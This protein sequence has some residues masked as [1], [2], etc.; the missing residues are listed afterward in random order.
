[1]STYW[2]WIGI[3]MTLMPEE[4]KNTTSVRELKGIYT[5]RPIAVLGAGPNLP[6]DLEKIPK[7]SILI[8]VNHHAEFGGL[9]RLDYMCF[10]DSPKHRPEA[11]AFTNDFIGRRLT[12]IK[13][14]SDWLVDVPYMYFGLTF[15]FAVWAAFWMGGNPIILCGFDC[16]TTG[17]HFHDGNRGLN[18]EEYYKHMHIW[19]RVFAEIE[20]P[21][22]IIVMSGPLKMLFGRKNIHKKTPSTGRKNTRLSAL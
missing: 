16:H 18:I 20:H 19:K 9:V 6:G 10:A 7:D 13:E 5:G 14:Y 12:F 4:R 11:M 17:G 2:I 1:M 15:P 3:L 22:R 21:E 8:G